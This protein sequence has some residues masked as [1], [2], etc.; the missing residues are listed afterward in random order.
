[1][2]LEH[3]ISGGLSGTSQSSGIESID[4]TGEDASGYLPTSIYKIHED[5]RVRERERES[6]MVLG[7]Q[8]TGCHLWT[9]SMSVLHTK[10]KRL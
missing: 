2:T 3:L 1:V 6:D 4:L 8:S 5:P 10:I 9:I 7:I